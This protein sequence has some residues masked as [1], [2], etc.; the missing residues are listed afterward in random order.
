MND[1]NRIDKALYFYYKHMNKRYDLKNGNLKN[2]LSAM[3]LKNIILR[4]S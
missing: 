3:D 2:L 4:K 1:I